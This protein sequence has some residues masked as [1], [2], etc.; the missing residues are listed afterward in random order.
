MQAG[1]LRAAEFSN[2]QLIAQQ[3]W[4]IFEQAKRKGFESNILLGVHADGWMRPN[5]KLQVARSQQSRTLNLEIVLPNW[6]PISRVTVL[7][8]QD[9]DTKVKSLSCGVTMGLS[10]SNFL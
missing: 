1:N 8:Q 7:V 5:V 2:S 4:E 10:Q 3:Y 6:A 9:R